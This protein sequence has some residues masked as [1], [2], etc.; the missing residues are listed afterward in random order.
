LNRSQLDRS[1]LT[2]ANEFVRIDYASDAPIVPG[3]GACIGLIGPHHAAAA[4]NDHILLAARYLRRQSDFKLYGG[5]DLKG[6]VGANVNSG[7]TQI[8]GH[9]AAGFTRG[10][11]L[12]NLDRQLQRKPFPGTCFGHDS[13]SAVALRSNG[14]A[15]KQA[16]NNENSQLKNDEQL[17]ALYHGK[18]RKRSLDYLRNLGRN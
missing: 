4:L 7:S 8:A 2:V 15:E 5:T 11:F 17:T 6:S 10:I 1:R 3:F 12:M 16:G 14:K 13:S 9:P 18:Y